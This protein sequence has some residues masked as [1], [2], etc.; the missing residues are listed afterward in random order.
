VEQFLISTVK[1]NTVEIDPEFKF[2]EV[3]KLLKGIEGLRIGPPEDAGDPDGTENNYID[4]R[5]ITTFGR[6]GS[7]FHDF[8]SAGKRGRIQVFNN[9]MSL[10]RF[11]NDDINLPVEMFYMNL[12]TG[13]ITITGGF[14]VAGATRIDDFQSVI[15]DNINTLILTKE[16]ESIAR[17]NQVQQNLDDHVTDFTNRN[18]VV[19]NALDRRGD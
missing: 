3:L 14:T 15:I 9:K 6:L 4:L 7:A 8:V 17:D 16:S 13:A 19:D 12:T 18:Q 2:D 11:T 5:S 1:G 10:F